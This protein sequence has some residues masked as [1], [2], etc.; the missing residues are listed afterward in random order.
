MRRNLGDRALVEPANAANAVGPYLAGK[1]SRTGKCG[2]ENYCAGRRA[3]RGFRTGAWRRAEPRVEVPESRGH[4]LKAASRAASREAERELILKA[5]A[6][7]AMEPKAGRTGIADQL[8]VIALQIEADRRAGFRS[9]TSEAGDEMFRRLQF[10]C[11][12]CASGGDCDAGACAGRIRPQEA[13]ASRTIPAMAG[14]DAKK[15]ATADPNYVIGAQDVLDISVWKE[16]DVSRVVPVRPDGKISLPLLN[17]VQAAGLTPTQL[18]AADHR[19]P[20]KICDESAGDGDRH[21]DQQ[22]ARLSY[23]E[24]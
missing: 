21:D 15:S 10:S 6:H 16:P 24:K 18:A 20:E 3:T 11:W 23:S 2:E 7:H 12:L 5:L 22:P 14:E 9:R 17:D 1:Y 19:K 4:S 13:S 8:Q